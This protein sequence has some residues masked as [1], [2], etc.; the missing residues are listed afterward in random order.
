MAL[1]DEGTANRCNKADGHSPNVFS[2][3]PAQELPRYGLTILNVIG[4]Q[5][6][7]FVPVLELMDAVVVVADMTN[8]VVVPVH[9][10]FGIAPPI[11]VA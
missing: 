9:G 7:Q 3:V 6:P 1:C 8:P 10:F 11:S 2:M 5:V 4:V